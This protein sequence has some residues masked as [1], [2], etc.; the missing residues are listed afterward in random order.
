MISHGI[1]SV[2]FLETKP[3]RDFFGKHMGYP[4][5]SYTYPI[6]LYIYPKNLGKLMLNHDRS[7]REL[8]TG[9]MIRIG[10]IPGDVNSFVN[11]ESALILH[12]LVG[13]LEHGWIMT[14]HLFGMSSSQLTNSIIFQRGRSTTSVGYVTLE[15][16]ESNPI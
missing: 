10:M 1:S 6:F 15:L 14:F 4:Q 11:C 13:G 9:M 2:H 12:V 8:L 3:V 16:W 7:R 5:F